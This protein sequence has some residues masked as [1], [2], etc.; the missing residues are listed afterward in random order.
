ME[1]EARRELLEEN[2]E[3]TDRTAEAASDS[4]KPEQP[5]AEKTDPNSPLDEATEDP[6][7]RVNVVV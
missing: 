5:L 3:E 7:Q 1:M 6:G 2:M 4:S